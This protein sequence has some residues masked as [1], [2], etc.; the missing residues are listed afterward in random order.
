MVS[1]M[2]PVPRHAAPPKLM[3]K[4]KKR[5]VVVRAMDERRKRGKNRPWNY[6]KRFC[7]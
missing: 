3:A 4:D 6:G 1:R 2:A 7:E 5:F